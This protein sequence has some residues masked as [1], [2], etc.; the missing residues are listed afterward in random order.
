MVRKKVKDKKVLIYQGKDEFYEKI[1]IG[2]KNKKYVP[3]V[4]I[5]FSELIKK[6]R[7]ENPQILLLDYSDFGYDVL[8][9]FCGNNNIK[10]FIIA[11][12]EKDILFNKNNVN[13]FFELEDFMVKPILVEELI[14]RIDRIFNNNFNMTQLIDRKYFKIDIKNYELY[15]NNKQI[16]AAPKEIELLYKLTINENLLLTREQLLDEVWGYQYVGPTRTVDV[17]IKRLRYKLKEI[18][19]KCK[20]E[21]VWGVGYIFK[22]TD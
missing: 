7:E 20:I 1:E 19:K 11:F 14:L 15:V 21:T 17:H 5:N 8:N 13:K 9:F 16:K 22:I 10:I 6:F 3:I 2:L 12:L 18:S 4:A